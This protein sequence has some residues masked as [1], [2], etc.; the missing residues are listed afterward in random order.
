MIAVNRWRRRA[1]GKNGETREAVW[2][3]DRQTERQTERHS[4]PDT[5]D[6]AVCI[7]KWRCV[8]DTERAKKLS[9]LFANLFALFTTITTK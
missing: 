4:A 3:T 9:L 8:C 2:Q 5:H 6:L 1:N 7:I